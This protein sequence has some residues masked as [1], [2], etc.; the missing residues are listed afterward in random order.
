MTTG[1]RWGGSS[2]ED[3]LLTRLYQQ[4][5]ERHAARYAA[6]YDIHAGLARYQAWLREHAAGERAT[7]EVI[8]PT[9][10]MALR[11]TASGIG[12]MP[13]PAFG[14]VAVASGSR[15]RPTSRSQRP[16]VRADLDA[17]RA[18]TELYAASYYRSLVRL[19]AMLTHDISVAEEVVQDSFVALHGGW[20]R[21]TDA[22]RALLYLR[23]SVVNRCRSVLR[24]RVAT[25][26][27]AP[28]LGPDMA[29]G[30]QEDTSQLEALP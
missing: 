4:V 6:S 27:L 3:E 15:D 28:K 18:V 22:D 20:R 5:T 9:S 25:E 2:S 13:G 24:H 14:E 1:G 17:D 29:E 10:V 16:E 8:Q 11:A 19:A 21:L 12:A 30:E 7:T 26:E 23:Q